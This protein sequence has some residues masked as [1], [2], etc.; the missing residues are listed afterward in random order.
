MLGSE[1]GRDEDDGVK[2]GSFV[3]LIE[4]EGIVDGCSDGFS[5]NVSAL[6]ACCVCDGTGT[7]GAGS[8]GTGS[9]IMDDDEG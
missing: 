7:A 2:L 8:A 4:A 1:D 6:C 5:D 9:A 3:G